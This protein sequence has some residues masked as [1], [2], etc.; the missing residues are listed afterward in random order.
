M[1]A[2]VA[3][4]YTSTAR[5]QLY[6]LVVGIQDF[7]N[8]SLNLRF[9]VADATAIAQML[10]NKAKPL[11]DKVNIEQ[12]TT[13]KA[14]TKTAL[15]GALNRYR[16]ISPLDSFVF[17]VA[18]HGTVD[19]DLATRE[20]F[21]IP[22]NVNTITAEAIRRDAVSEAELK[23]A[24]GNIPATQKL[25]LLD[26][27][28]AGGV[29][30]TM[31]ATT[32][33][34]VEELAAIKI[35]AVAVTSTVLSASASEQEALEGQ[36]GH[37]LFTWVL[38]QGLGGQADPWKHGSVNTLDLAAYVNHEVPVIAE[39]HFKRRQDPNVD[40]HGQSFEVVSLR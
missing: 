29:G 40:T 20:Y 25:V 36:D 35:L 17:Y 26:T 4:H 16:K 5:P 14:T 1:H 23:E 28:H 12:L 33:P 32:K 3:A 9:S 6:A 30:Q 11:Y 18:S 19:G 13:P 7:D 21:L 31:M 24:I 37:G 10:Q 22:S 39:Q 2:T 15:L 27:C 34:G 38:L 8:A